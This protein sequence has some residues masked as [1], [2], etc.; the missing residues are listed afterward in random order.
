MFISPGSSIRPWLQPKSN[1]LGSSWRHLT[2]TSSDGLP[3]A[4]GPFRRDLI[5]SKHRN[6]GNARPLDRACEASRQVWLRKCDAELA[7]SS[8]PLIGVGMHSWRGVWWGGRD[9]RTAVGSGGVG[10][11]EVVG[12]PRRSVATSRFCLICRFVLFWGDAV[13]LQPL[14]CRQVS[15][16][17]IYKFLLSLIPRICCP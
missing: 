17:F 12:M 7:G 2:D 13:Y 15:H 6:P 11:V 5:R 1:Q 9:R 10:E 8:L 4:P 16:Y 3:T 14:S